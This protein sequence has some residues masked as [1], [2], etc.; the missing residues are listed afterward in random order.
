MRCIYELD[1]F[2]SWVS[3]KDVE[4]LAFCALLNEFIACICKAYD[5]STNLPRTTT[6]AFLALMLYLT[7]QI[8]DLFA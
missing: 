3:T 5:S 2:S 6:L 4:A 7:L 1:L 8:A